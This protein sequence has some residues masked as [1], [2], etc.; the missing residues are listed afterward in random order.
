VSAS[1]F[2]DAPPTPTVPLVNHR[3]LFLP[4][5]GVVVAVAW[6][7]AVVAVQAADPAARPFEISG[8]YPH[9]AVFN[10]EQECGTGAVV[11]WAD[12]LWVITYAPHK[13]RGSTDKLYE[14]T[15]DLTQIIR[16]ESIGG[17]PANRFI[18]RESQQLFIGPYAIDAQRNV[19]VIPYE[20]MFGRPTGNAR[21]LRDPAN[22]VYYASME[23]G[24]YEVDVR[25]LA[26][27]ELFRDEQ[28]KE[29]FRR[30][31]LPGYH[32]KGLYSGQGV[33]VY[34]NN[35][36]NS[37][38]ARQKP[39]IPSG[40]L[41]EWDGVSE[42][43]T[44]VR[45]NQFTEVTGPGDL[46]GNPNPATDPIWSIGWDHRSLLLMV[47]NAGRWHAYR[48]PK[49]SH[50]YDGAHGWNT[51][52]P[53][54]RDIGEQDLLMTMHGTFWRFPRTFSS[55]QSAGIAP[56]SNYLKVVGDFTRWGDRIVLGCDDTALSEFLNKRRAKGKLAAPGQSQSN[57]WFLD[58]AQL[59][60]LGPALGRG[61][62]W[63]D[64]AVSRDTPSDAYLF[65]GY[66]QRTLHLAHDAGAAVA[67]T[68]EVDRA[69]DNR[70]TT[71]RTVEVPASGYAWTSFAADERGAWIRV[72]AARDLGRATAFFAFR[73]RDDR[74]AAPAE[75]RFA[76]LA[77]DGTAAPVTG[78]LLHARGS[79]RKTLGVAA[80]DG[81]YEMGPDMKL[82]R[83]D[84]AGALAWMR[85]N[86]AIPADAVTFDA[87]SVIY[88]DE[89]GKRFRLP[90]GRRDYAATGPLGAERTV[91]E[92]CTERDL[93]N[94]AGTF[95]ELPAENA[96]G[97]A[98]VRPVATHLRRIHDFATW[99]GLLVMSGIETKTPA[100]NRHLIRSDDG[101]AAVWVGAVDDLW[102]L[103]KP[104]GEGGPWHETQV[105]A[106]EPS[107][108]Y[109]MTGYD[110]KTLRL[111]HRGTRPVTMKVEVDL[112]GNGTWGEYGSVDVPAG[113]VEEHVFPAGYQA[114]WI[115]VSANIDTTATAWFV[116]D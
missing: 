49:G 55:A 1:I 11:P 96:G 33:L 99:R 19:R 28:L 18:H 64:E 110:R 50:S 83:S 48:L 73:A 111:S 89:A 69:G 112:S 59:D 43:W 58:P 63:L 15:P 106:G 12:R 42:K 101:R 116:Y 81:F 44:V 93:L 41:A 27:T 6:C 8:I 105:R 72:R 40:A 22:K 113:R 115:R 84:E 2:P 102:S 31:G 32:G 65:S 85:E 86:V 94:C 14:I 103:G 108:P 60:R 78:G 47:R 95:F 61:A 45:R 52:W 82:G 109:L 38:L 87:A 77:R 90:K 66:E 79:G 39:D 70:W 114:Y 21:H 80:A 23:E 91:R 76:G 17:T 54:I 20:K 37:P 5:R 3:C 71:L 25:T 35:G 88:T 92:V 29:P 67:F 57:L 9:L 16:P 30:A 75:A 24:F 53:R 13:P 62:V 107:E 51:E 26:V 98:K 36:E 56:R 46:S 97:I 74:P 7:V 34:A 104:V 100:D 10:Q 68:L 4:I